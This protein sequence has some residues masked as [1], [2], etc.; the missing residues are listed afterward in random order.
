V[1]ITA[2]LM[3][4]LQGCGTPR[5]TPIAAEDSTPPLE[6][7]L[8][9]GDEVDVGFF[10]APELNVVQR[11]RPDG[12]LSLRLADD[13]QA[14]GKTVTELERDLV[15]LYKGQIQV[16]AIDVVVRTGPS[17]IVSGSVRTPGRV[18]L[19]RPLTVLDAVMSSGGF[20]FERARLSSVMVIRNDGKNYRGHRLDMRDTLE[21]RGAVFYVKPNDIVFVPSTPIVAANQ[22]VEQYI[23]KML[24]RLGLGYSTAGEVTVY[25]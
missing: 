16:R 4:L 5:P 7:R 6:I 20:D 10:G 19:T 23:N 21:G 9:P 18:E 17:V 8:T 15:E 14:A 11:I 12:R 1:C 13:I 24:P 25:R 22:W 2:L 3:G